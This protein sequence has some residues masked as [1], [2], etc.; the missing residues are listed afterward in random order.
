[1]HAHAICLNLI[2]YGDLNT[3][4]PCHSP[5]HSP[6]QVE[7]SKM[8]MEKFHKANNNLASEITQ[9]GVVGGCGCLC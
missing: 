8:E 1:M 2:E 4:S 5:C 6:L 9:V 7:M 3:H